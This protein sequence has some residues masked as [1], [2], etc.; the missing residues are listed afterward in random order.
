MSPAK[1]WIFCG[2][3]VLVS[4]L[5]YV[6][7]QQ[8]PPADPGL[9]ADIRA[10]GTPVKFDSA[11]HTR[12]VDSALRVAD[13]LLRHS[14][15]ALPLGTGDLFGGPMSLAQQKRWD[16]IRAES[17][18]RANAANEIATALSR[19]QY[20]KELENKFLDEGM[21]ITVT[22]P[23]VHNTTLHLQ[24]IL[25]GRVFAHQLEKTDALWQAWRNMGFKRVELEGYD[26]G[27]AWTL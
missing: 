6:G 13:S 5:F 25:A 3:A 14:S 17:E 8:P 1:A 7:A 27:V 9:A 10:A 19:R 12:A 18:Q 20:A 22:T 16:R 11:A 23:G 15:T 24:Y 21:D 2:L 26:Y 4:I